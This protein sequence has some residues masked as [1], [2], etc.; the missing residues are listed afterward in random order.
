MPLVDYASSD[1]EADIPAEDIAKSKQ[2]PPKSLL[3]KHVKLPPL[4]ETFLDLYASTVR[5]SSVD[6]PA[7][8]GG[9]K[10]TTPHVQGNWPT[11]L[12]IECEHPKPPPHFPLTKQLS[13]QKQG[14]PNGEV[15]HILQTLI[16]DIQEADPSIPITSHL[17]SDVGTPLPLHISLSRPIG[18]MADIKDAFLVALKSKMPTCDVPP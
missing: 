5:T 17:T 13:L 6:D 9:R 15:F 12:Y 7:L 3:R 16:K 11:H 14:L 2:S 18:F 1:D 8:H 4:P 10:R